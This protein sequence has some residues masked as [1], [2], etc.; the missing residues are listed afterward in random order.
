[1]EFVMKK[2]LVFCCF[3]L[4]IVGCDKNDKTNQGDSREIRV[5]ECDKFLKFLEKM[6]ECT[7]RKVPEGKNKDSFKDSFL[8]MKTALLSNN[9]RSKE[10]LK[11]ICL[12]QEKTVKKIMEPYNCDIQ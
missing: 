2:L 6:T 1:M 3:F 12:E 11:S 8:R 9:N 7:E 5:S 4:L 10:D